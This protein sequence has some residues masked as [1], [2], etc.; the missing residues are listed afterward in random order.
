MNDATFSKLINGQEIRV[1][2]DPLL[3]SNV[4]RVLASLPDTATGAVVLHGD[5]NEASLSVVGKVGEHWTVVAS[6]YRKW[7]GEM[8]GE[9]EVR[10]SW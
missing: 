3:Q 8:N 1:F 2:S 6:G 10:Y 5:L 9:A 7:S 4:D